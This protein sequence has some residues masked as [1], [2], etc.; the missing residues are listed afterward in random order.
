MFPGSAMVPSAAKYTVWRVRKNVK[1]RKAKQEKAKR[2][3]LNELENIEDQDTLVTDKTAEANI[4][5]QKDNAKKSIKTPETKSQFTCIPEIEITSAEI[6]DKFVIP[7][8]TVTSA[9]ISDP[10]KIIITDHGVNAEWDVH[11]LQVREQKLEAKSTPETM[12]QFTCIPGIEITCAEIFDKFVIPQ[13]T[14]TPAEISDPPNIIIIDQG[15]NDGAKLFQTESDIRGM[16]EIKHDVNSYKE[17]QKIISCRKDGSSSRSRTD[18]DAISFDGSSS[19]NL[20]PLNLRQ[21][22][23]IE[24]TNRIVYSPPEILVTGKD[25]E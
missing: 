10:P 17:L 2:A 8:I 21:T 9:E 16:W 18:L 5:R 14:V 22:A 19:L 3:V 15:M 20:N 24:Q 4:R 13:I 6:F 1:K 25:F 23:N 12:I 7:Q 11:S